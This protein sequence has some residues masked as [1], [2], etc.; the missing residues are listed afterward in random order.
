MVSLTAAETKIVLTLCNFRAFD[1]ELLFIAESFRWPIDE[2]AVNWTEIEGS[3]LTP[4]MS[5]LQ[6]G[7]DLVLIWL[8]YQ[9]G[10]WKL[11]PPPKTG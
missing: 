5:S 11:T 8:R 2:I 4:L 9:I 3:K 10:A 6:M 1:V 7:R